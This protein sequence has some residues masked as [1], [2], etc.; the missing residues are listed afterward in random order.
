MSFELTVSLLRALEMILTIAPEIFKDSARPNSDLLLGRVC[1]LIGQILAR[2]TVPPGCFQHVVDMCLPDLSAVTH[3]G[4][5]APTLGVL[6]ALLKDELTEEETMTHVPRISR[7]LLTD[8]SFYIASLEFTLGEVK[9]PIHQQNTP[10]GNFDPKTR[11]HIDPMTN[12]VRVPTVRDAVQTPIITF[13][14]KHC[15]FYCFNH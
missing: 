8:P 7:I 10:R 14:L 11:Q 15:K 12:E 5:I 1:Q 9:T 2:V 3:F 13:N 6:L 4:F